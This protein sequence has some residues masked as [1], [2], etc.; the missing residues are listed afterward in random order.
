MAFPGV[1]AEAL[2]LAL[3]EVALSTGSACTS[4]R[5]EPSHVLRALGISQARALGTIRIGLGRSTSESEVDDSGGSSDG[6]PSPGSRKRHAL[7]GCPP[8]GS[9]TDF[10]APASSAVD[11]FPTRG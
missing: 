4:A 5:R 2:L 11:G 1:E 8:G 7:P 10:P 3:P 6:G 9:R